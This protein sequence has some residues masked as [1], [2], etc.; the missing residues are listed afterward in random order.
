MLPVGVVD[1]RQE[2]REVLRRASLADEDRH[3]R[4]DLRQ[5]LVRRE[6][7]VVRRDARRRIAEKRLAVSAGEVSVDRLAGGLCRGDLAEHFGVTG[8]DARDVHQLA[9]C[10]ELGMER[11]ETCGVRG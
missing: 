5:G 2:I 1:G 8:K 9:E 11:E 3:P 7:F 4:G 10:D 6:R